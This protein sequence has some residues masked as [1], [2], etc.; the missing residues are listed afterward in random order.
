ML[1]QISQN[2][3]RNFRK[4]QRRHKDKS[5]ET[6]RNVFTAQKDN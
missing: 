2:E 5:C 1:K 3:K 4:I 6:K